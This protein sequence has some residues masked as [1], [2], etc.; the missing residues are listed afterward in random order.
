MNITHYTHTQP[1]RPKPSTGCLEQ[2]EVLYL[3][4]T[5]SRV[6]PHGMTSGFVVCSPTVQSLV[7][8]SSSVQPRDKKSKKNGMGTRRHPPGASRWTTSSPIQNDWSHPSHESCWQEG[9]M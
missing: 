2:R 5:G 7:L 6:H 3:P 1:H 4:R 8:V 9:D